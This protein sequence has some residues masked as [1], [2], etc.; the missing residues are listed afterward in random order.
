MKNNKILVAVYGTLRQGQGNW[1]WYLDNNESKFL[2]TFRTEPKFEMYSLGGFPAVKEKGDSQITVEVFEVTP[3]VKKGLDGLEG[4]HGEGHHNMYDVTNLKTPYGTAV[5]YVMNNREFPS[6]RKIVS[7]D[8]L[9]R[10]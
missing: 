6:D 5:M 7:G 3:S 2:G 10:S 9:K 4:Y 8:W 1:R